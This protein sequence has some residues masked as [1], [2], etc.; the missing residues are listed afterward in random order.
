MSQH[1]ALGPRTT[2]LPGVAPHVAISRL[3]LSLHLADGDART[4]ALS[5]A[6]SGLEA[7]LELT[8]EL[9]GE[10]DLARVTA[11]LSLLTD[12]ANTL[13]TWQPSGYRGPALT[14]LEEQLLAFQAAHKLR[15]ALRQLARWGADHSGPWRTPRAA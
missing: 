8:Q 1:P 6:P 12:G 9:P 4:L 13:V 5:R 7:V 14:R 11:D 2:R 10:P 15:A 3:L